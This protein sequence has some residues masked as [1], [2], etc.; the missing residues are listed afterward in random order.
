MGI[1][2]NLKLERN[3]TCFNLY[4][5]VVCFVFCV[6]CQISSKC[7]KPKAQSSSSRFKRSTAQVSS[8]RSQV[9][10]LQRYCATSYLWFFHLWSAMCDNCD[11]CLCFVLC[12]MCHCV[13]C[14]CLL[15]AGSL[16]TADCS[17]FNCELSLWIVKCKT[18]NCES[19]SCELWI[20][21]YEVWS[22]ERVSCDFWV[23]RLW[24]V[25]CELCEPVIRFPFSINC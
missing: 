15:L 10:S 4:F 24:A 6:K 25:R 18:M 16:L 19:L 5:A 7:S 3:I 23:A 1:R 17:W 13:L 21:S 2:G 14:H 12:V 22:C 8:L 9:S 20:V 11:L